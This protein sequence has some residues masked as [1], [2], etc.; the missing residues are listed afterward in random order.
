VI[1]RPVRSTARPQHRDVVV[2]GAGP[3]G[4]GVAAVLGAL[5]IHDVEVLDRA[6]I[7]ASFRAWPRGT[8]LIT[9]SFPSNGFGAPD[10]NAITVDTAPSLSLQTEHPTGPQYAGYLEFV[11]EHHDIE[12]AAPVEVTDVSPERGGR[13][14]V[15][16]DDGDR[17]ARAVVWAAGELPYVATPGI[18]GA[19][20][21][22]HSSTV[23]AWEAVHGEHVVVVGGYESG[24][25]AACHLVDLGRHVTVLDPDA[26][27]RSLDT[28]PSLSLSPVTLERLRDALGTGR[29]ALVDDARVEGIHTAEAGFTVA[30]ADGRR[31]HCDGP[32]LLATGFRSS[33][34][35]VRDRFAF[36]EHG[37]VVTEEA[38]ESTVVPGLYL[39]GPMLVHRGLSFCFIYKFR[40]RFA[41]V[42]R[43]VAGR[44]GVDAAPLEWLRPHG[45]LLDDLDCCDVSCAC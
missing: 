9:P 44:L 12:V 37:V 7:G 24:V 39:A 43:G 10:L 26:P 2:V 29:L 34:D 45:F 8:R 21:A 15:H 4:L 25:D 35:I 28:D 5:G 42:A 16:T 11:A 3:A 13:L 36:D 27:W 17:V 20:H 19:E 32:P 30:A 31:W 40:Q 1:R 18:V 38:D 6:G 33:L 41:V 23:R 22:V 14:R